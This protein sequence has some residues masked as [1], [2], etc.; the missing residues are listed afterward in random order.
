MEH[1]LAD[2]TKERAGTGR[3]VI[4]MWHE[5]IF[6][7]PYVYARL[8]FQAHVLVS[9]SNAGEIAARI[10]DACGHAV[11]R[12]GTSRRGSRS[13]PTAI[14]TAIRWMQEHEDGIFATPVDG[15]RGPPHRIKPGSL[16]VARACRAPVVCVRLWFQ[17]CVRLA[18]WDRA[19]LPL[20]FGDVHI[21]VG[22]P[23]PL[24]A[25]AENRDDLET[26]RVSRERELIEL[27]LRSHADTR[28]PVPPHLV[29]PA[30]D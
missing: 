7:A 13:R 8:G 26:F 25:N 11:S 10:S 18:T 20:P 28:T 9:Q 27:T 30:S 12:G 19:M 24:P 22:K 23:C 15:S 2:L 3:M 21:Y 5:E 1:G 14:R 6:A 29:A 16:L 4:L 17:H